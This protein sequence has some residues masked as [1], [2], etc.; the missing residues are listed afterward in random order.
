LRL[1]WVNFRDSIIGG[2]YAT[3]E[4]KPHRHHALWLVSFCVL[5]LTSCHNSSLLERL[6]SA[7]SPTPRDF[8]FP[9][10]YPATIASLADYHIPVGA[11]FFNHRSPASLLED[12]DALGFRTVGSYE[13]GRFYASVHP[14]LTYRMA[15]VEYV[16]R[17]AF[18][19]WAFE[20]DDNANHLLDAV[21]ESLKEGIVK[22]KWIVDPFLAGTETINFQDVVPLCRL[23]LKLVPGV[24][25]QLSREGSH[26]GVME[27]AVYY[28]AVEPGGA[29]DPLVE[30]VTRVCI[31]GNRTTSHIYLLDYW[32]GRRLH[33]YALELYRRLEDLRRE[34]AERRRAER[35]GEDPSDNDD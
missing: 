13:D 27:I 23:W 5:L 3:R 25:Q 6:Q 21:F 10:G 22:G 18:G 15:E 32:H 28:E 1:N 31:F 29:T 19:E 34:Y 24:S 17:T 7:D 35:E 14:A 16:E 30:R 11:E 33:T 4:S 20:G 26:V 12:V 2:K 8:A 9:S